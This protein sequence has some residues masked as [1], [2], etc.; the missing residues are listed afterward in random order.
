M[1]VLTDEWCKNL[2]EQAHDWLQSLDAQP[3]PLE[4]WLRSQ[5]NV[6]R[7]GFYFAA[8]LEF[9]VRKCPVLASDTTG[10]VLT[11]QQVHAGIDGQC[12]GQLK[13][14][15]ERATASGARELAHW[16]SHVKFFAWCPDE[17]DVESTPI[18]VTDTESA[19]DKVSVADSVSVAET[20]ADNAATEEG[21]DLVCPRWQRK[22]RLHPMP[23]EPSDECLATYIGPF[24]G[25]NLLHRVVELRRKLSLSA[26]PAVR[27]FLTAHFQ[28][29]V[30]DEGVSSAIA[31]T[32]ARKAVS[33]P[34]D[35]PASLPAVDLRSESVVRGYLFYPLGS[36]SKGAPVNNTAAA[37]TVPASMMAAD[38]SS[39]VSCDHSRGWWT[40]SLDALLDCC[41]PS[42]MWALPGNGAG[43][44]DDACGALGGKLHWLGPAVA[45]CAS[46]ADGASSGVPKIEGIPTLGVEA[47][48]LLTTSEMRTTLASLHRAGPSWA[49]GWAGWGANDDGSSPAALLLLQMLPA[50]QLRAPLNGTVW[51]EASRGFLMP[52]EWDPSPLR[53]VQPL[54]L[55]SGMRQKQ[56]AGGAL[57]DADYRAADQA[58]AVAPGKLAVRCG[59]EGGYG[60]HADADESAL[61]ACTEA[62]ESSWRR[63]VQIQTNAG[64]G[65]DGDDDTAI[66]DAV[67][68]DV[69]AAWRK[70]APSHTDEIHELSLAALEAC[71]WCEAQLAATDGATAEAV[72]THLER[73]HV[74]VRSLFSS[75]AQVGGDATATATKAKVKGSRPKGGAANSR[76]ALAKTT[77]ARS[78]TRSL[79]VRG[80]VRLLRIVFESREQQRFLGSLLVASLATSTALE[81]NADATVMLATL[82]ADTMCGRL[83]VPQSLIVEAVQLF[84]VR[85][86]PTNGVDASTRRRGSS[87][88]PPRLPLSVIADYVRPLL[89]AASSVN[90][91]GEGGE[92]AEPANDDMMLRNVTQLLRQLR[93]VHLDLVD[94]EDVIRRLVDANQWVYAEQLALASIEEAA[95]LRAAEPTHDEAGSGPSGRAAPPEGAEPP[96][97]DDF[98]RYV[99]L[100]KAAK[101]ATVATV[102][103]SEAA[104]GGNVLRKWA[105]GG[106]SV[107]RVAA[108]LGGYIKRSERLLTDGSKEGPANNG[109]WSSPFGGRLP[110]LPSALVHDVLNAHEESAVSSFTSGAAACATE[111]RTN[112]D[113]QKLLLLLLQLARQRMNKKLVAKLSKLVHDEADTSHAQR[114]SQIT[115]LVGHRELAVALTYAGTDRLLQLHLIKLLLAADLRA[116]A[117]EVVRAKQLSPSLLME[118]TNGHGSDGEGSEDDALAEV[119]AKPGLTTSAG[120]I[121]SLVPYAL[122]DG[123]QVECFDVAAEAATAEAALAR[124]RDVVTSGSVLP[125]IG[126]DAEW[127]AGKPVALVQLAVP[128]HCVLLRVHTSLLAENPQ[129]PPMPP[130]LHSLLSDKAIIKAGVGIAHDLKLIREQL[131]VHAS[132]VLDL[133]MI[134]AREGIMHAGLQRLTAEVLGLHLDKRP[135]LRCGNWEAPTLSD[136]QVVYAAMDAH[137]AIDI[138]KSMYRVYVSARG[139][140]ALDAISWCATLV[141]CDSAKG[142]SRKQ[143]PQAGTSNQLPTAPAVNV[144]L[145]ATAT[146]SGAESI[147][148]PGS[149]SEEQRPRWVDPHSKE[150]LSSLPPLTSIDLMSKLASLDFDETAAHLVDANAMVEEDAVAVREQRPACLHVKS[151]ALFAT[152]S[153][154]VAVLPAHRKLDPFKIAKHLKLTLTS[155]KAMSKQV[156]LATPSECVEYFGYRPG[157]VPPLG[158]RE[159]STLVIV[160]TECVSHPAALL[161]GGGDF[162]SLLRL[163]PAALVTQPHVSVADLSEGAAAPVSTMGSVPETSGALSNRYQATTSAAASCTSTVTSSATMAGSALAPG[164]VDTAEGV[165]AAVADVLIDDPRFLVDSMMGRLLRWLRVLGVDT[166]LRD[167]GEKIEELFDRARSERRIILTRDRKVAERRDMGSVAIFVVGS[168]EPREQLREVVTHFGLRLSADEFMMRCSVC[169]GRGYYN[170][171]KAHAAEHGCP[172]KVLETVDD[173]YVCRS[174]GKL[175]WEGPKSNNAFDHFASVLDGFGAVASLQ[176]SASWDA[177][178]GVERGKGCGELADPVADVDV[179]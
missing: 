81:A 69:N 36:S 61:G 157:T 44:R 73:F 34:A 158:H 144:C 143:Q 135:E 128:G 15:F 70:L 118:S 32:A 50:R 12:A 75:N 53:R 18:S 169:N 85:A 20:N 103:A 96:E 83:R 66:A 112:V 126:I 38:D 64:G 17:S 89:R 68:V 19:A 42:S 155:R 93:V 4:A 24:L 100:Q 130:S 21:V 159:G 55:R 52:P 49:P 172:P 97:G 5:R 84:D 133:Q 123:S 170:V 124:M 173:F 14:V 87:A 121:S 141:D 117:A 161:A 9:W 99:D 59:A 165:P 107:Q 60:P 175:Y 88:A 160:D 168:D 77:I 54:G 150:S 92:A 7:L 71:T 63:R 179:S 164:D 13:L 171:D 134:A 131:G 113:D 146:Q 149:G 16:E 58:F 167:D 139:T 65:G 51:L 47:C 145:P 114:T 142:R 62:A 125:V 98:Q 111:P 28:K 132:G 78:I 115:R 110:D 40:R 22:E 122:P 1:P 108:A 140:A 106:E 2:C 101:A 30:T 174:C 102:R 162:G 31:P 86:E 11:Q 152:G 147:A 137:V 177:E 37:A 46:Q 136:S 10:N 6:R 166:L 129:P 56:K 119:G 72:D 91:S 156:R 23:S 104:D 27:S 105:D 43:V 127:V 45:V 41:D 74:A 35:A 76:F 57:V 82:L 94:H 39:P 48:A 80:A 153:P 26:A 154:A 109:G 95:A 67:V 116:A 148:L 25:E 8:L 163:M 33:A 151:L 176:R 138:F 29:R 3:E 79:R 90:V 178:H 120:A